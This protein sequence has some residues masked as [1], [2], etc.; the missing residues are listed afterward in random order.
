MA[1]FSARAPSPRALRGGF[2]RGVL[3]PP[4]LGVSPILSLVHCNRCNLAEYI[5]MNLARDCNEALSGSGLAQA[6]IFAVL[7]RVSAMLGLGLGSGVCRFVKD[8]IE[9]LVLGL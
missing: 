5:A 2:Q 1:V 7:L 4:L 3:D 6:G 9:C 8:A